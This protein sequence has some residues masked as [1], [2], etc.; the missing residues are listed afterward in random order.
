MDKRLKWNAVGLEKKTHLLQKALVEQQS[1]VQDDHKREQ[2]KIKGF[3]EEIEHLLDR[4]LS[5][6]K[7][8]IPKLENIFRIQFPT[9][10]LVLLAL[11]RP[12]TRNIYEDLE[13]YF[14]N[15][16]LNPLKPNDYKELASSGEAGDVL[17]LIGDAVLD[18]AVVQLFWDSSIS[19]AGALTKKREELVNNQNLSL[20]CDK[21]DLFDY[22]LIR[23]KGHSTKSAKEKTIT[24]EKATLI[25]AIFGVIYL[26][27]GFE[28]LVRVVPMIQ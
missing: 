26:E 12:S 14:Q 17:A 16:S 27:F 2:R 1:L 5:I 8:I 24:H 6:Q 9:P 3:L 15:I 25:E 21:W 10:E 11:S 18:L 19:S 22:R 20:V 23:L 7:N 13:L 4:M 28:E